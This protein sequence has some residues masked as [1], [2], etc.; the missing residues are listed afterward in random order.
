MREVKGAPLY[1]YPFG[2]IQSVR[3]YLPD[4][5]ECFASRPISYRK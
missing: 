5:V 2:H 3:Q 4:W 1:R